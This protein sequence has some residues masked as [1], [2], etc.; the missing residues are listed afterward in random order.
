LQEIVAALESGCNM[1]P[2]IDNF[3]WPLP[4]TLPVDMRPICYFNGVKYAVH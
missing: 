1:I 2:V 4:E 3:H